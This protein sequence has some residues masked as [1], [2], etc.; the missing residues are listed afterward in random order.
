VCGVVHEHDTVCDGSR[1]NSKRSCACGP[2]HLTDDRVQI[3]EDVMRA[4]PLASCW[5]SDLHLDQ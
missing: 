3:I 5:L 2:G 4:R 1:S